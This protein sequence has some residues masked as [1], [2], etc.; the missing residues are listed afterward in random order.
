[1]RAFA[2][3]E[4]GNFPD[5]LRKRKLDWGVVVLEPDPLCSHALK[6]SQESVHSGEGLRTA[7]VVVR[8]VRNKF[9]VRGINECLLTRKSGCD[10]VK[11]TSWP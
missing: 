8:S 4:I 7:K 5:S 2:S 11:K 9:D 1:M 10:R 3:Y 6:A